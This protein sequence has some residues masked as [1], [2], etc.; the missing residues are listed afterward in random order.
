MP[1]RSSPF[2]AANPL[3]D[4]SLLYGP[5]IGGSLAYG[6]WLIALLDAQTA[7]CKIVERQTA[8]L[9]QPWLDPAA[10]PPS[11]QRVVDAVQGL[12]LFDP[13]A[14]QKTWA[15]WTQVWV[16]ALRHDAVEG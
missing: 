12:A 10:P 3:F 9:L 15:A 1:T 13:A 16:N 6:S 11:A 2:P 8:N 14:M 7:L 4:F 5:W